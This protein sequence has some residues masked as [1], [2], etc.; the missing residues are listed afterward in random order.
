MKKLLFAGFLLTAGATATYAQCDQK[1]VISSSKTEHLGA[2]STVTHSESDSTTV[3][4]DRTTLDV[5][6]KNVDRNQHMKGTVKSY[7]CNWSVPYKEGKT[8]IKGTLTNDE[9]ESRDL[10]I[11]VT[12]TGGKISFLAELPGDEDQRIR[13]VVDKF[14]GAK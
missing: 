1:A 6:I 5:T 9:G 7:D 10:T 2:D 12:G 11:T 3:A 8:V 14:E 13:L 4:F